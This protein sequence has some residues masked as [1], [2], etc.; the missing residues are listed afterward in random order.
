[1]NKQISDTFDNCELL[2]AEKAPQFIA[3]SDSDLVDKLIEHIHKVITSAD[4]F[5]AEYNFSLKALV[6]AA[7]GTFEQLSLIQ[8]AVNAMCEFLEVRKPI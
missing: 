7:K 4:A 2:G 1:M 8:K 5:L 3:S 6:N